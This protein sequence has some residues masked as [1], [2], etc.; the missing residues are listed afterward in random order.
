[1]FEKIRR[2]LERLGEQN[3]RQYGSGRLSCCGL[4]QSH[5]GAHV[6]R[7]LVERMKAVAQCKSG[8][9]ASLDSRTD[10]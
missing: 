7:D 6:N 1:M 10:G 5:S 8:Y 3:E 2:W 9:R 4:H